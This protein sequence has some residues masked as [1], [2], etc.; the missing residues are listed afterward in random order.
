MGLGQGGLRDQKTGQLQAWAAVIV[1]AIGVVILGLIGDTARSL[2]AFDRAAIASGELWRLVSAHFV[3]LGTS[4]LVLNLFGLG[5]V[6]YL[7]GQVYSQA[8]WV[9]TWI[10]SIFAV[11]A[12]L[13]FFAPELA[14]YVGLSG[15]L[16][17]LLVAGILGLAPKRVETWVLGLALLAKLGWEQLV[18]PLP[19]SE[20]AS[21]GNVIVDA[22]LFGTL[23]GLLAAILIRVRAK[24]SI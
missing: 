13:W 18:G 9:V 19:G 14:W 23:G 16:H 24:A 11:T 20:S 3:H 5:L 21:G 6:W 8:Q 10:L 4:H 2:L 17:G 22:H 15:V 7:V 12:G 1:V